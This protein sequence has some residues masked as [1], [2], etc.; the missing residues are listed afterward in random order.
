MLSQKILFGPGLSPD[1]IQVGEM[2]VFT[3]N[4]KE[5]V[6]QPNIP[7]EDIKLEIKHGSK[8]IEWHIFDNGDETFDVEWKPIT[9]GSYTFIAKVNGKQIADPI[10][11]EILGLKTEAPS[12]VPDTSYEVLLPEAPK[13]GESATLTLLD[14]TKKLTEKD[15]AVKVGGPSFTKTQLYDNGDRSFDVEFTLAKDGVYSFDITVKGTPIYGS[16]FSVLTLGQKKKEQEEQERLKRELRNKELMEQKANETQIVEP[17]QQ[18][19]ILDV[20]LRKTQKKN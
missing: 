19:P 1:E 11:I 16:P 18:R 6:G 12:Q 15:L 14:T 20:Q 4:P 10:T 7:K 13:I 8:L 17:E 2:T 3:I 9:P 5:A